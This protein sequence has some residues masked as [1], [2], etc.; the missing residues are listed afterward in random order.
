MSESLAEALPKEMA[1]CRE[2]LGQYRA[3]GPSGMFGAA[4]IEQDLRRA[5]KAVMEGDVVAMIQVYEALKE[6]ES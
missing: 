4:M 1:R 3:I 5:D 6:Y 2:L